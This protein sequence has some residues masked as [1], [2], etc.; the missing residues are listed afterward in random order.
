VKHGRFEQFYDARYF[1]DRDVWFLCDTN[2]KPY[3]GCKGNTLVFIAPDWPRYKYFL[4]AHATMCFMPVWSIEELQLV[5]ANI[6]PELSEERVQQLFL[7]YGGVP[8]Y[9]L[10]YAENKQQ[11]NLLDAA[12]T[13][14]V[15]AGVRAVINNTGVLA[16]STGIPAYMVVHMTAVDFI[17]NHLVWAS[18]H[19]FERFMN[20]QSSE[21]HTEAERFYDQVTRH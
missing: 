15:S 14:C 18:E 7:K 21:L 2:E 17:S 3:E 16:V 13:E 10:D 12:I 1:D 20:E 19:V 8:R 11:Q 6:Y 4:K 9:V 5:R